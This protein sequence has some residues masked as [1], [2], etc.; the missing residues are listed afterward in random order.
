MHQTIIT[1]NYFQHK[2]ETDLYVFTASGQTGQQTDQ[3]GLTAHRACTT[4]WDA[5]NGCTDRQMLPQVYNTTL[6]VQEYYRYLFHI[7]N[8][9]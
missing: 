6:I 9:L 4:A 5:K 8:S 2:T 7:K 1:E 3:T